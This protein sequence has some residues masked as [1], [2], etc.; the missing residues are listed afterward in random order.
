MRYGAGRPG[1]HA[2]TAGK[3]SLDVRRLQRDGHLSAGQRMNWRW[4]SGAT[5]DMA[6][7]HHAIRLTYRYKNRQGEWC[8][9]DQPIGIERTPCHYGGNRPWFTCPRCDR[10]AAILYLWNVPLCRT[11][12]RLVYPSQ[13][14]DAV[15]RSWRRARKIAKQLGPTDVD[16]WTLP[17]RPKGMREA[18]YARLWAAWLREDQLRDDMLT[19]FMAKFPGLL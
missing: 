3:L 12:A 6:T 19:V 15:A 7:E 17:R 11:C 1:W 2:K 13:T 4:S 10:R 18:T 14:E 16:A 8:A 5:I 9:V